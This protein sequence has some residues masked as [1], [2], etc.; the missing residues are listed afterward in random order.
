MTHLLFILIYWF[1]PS[2]DSV[3][4]RYEFNDES[5]LFLKGNTNVTAFKCDCSDNYRSGKVSYASD[6]STGKLTFFN[7]SIKIPSKSLDCRNRF[8]NR[9]LCESLKA[10]K[11]PEIE[12]K[13]LEAVPTH[14][15]GALDKNGL[16]K[17]K[18]KA[19]IK[20]AG[21]AKPQTF[22]VI[23]QKRGENQFRI[24][25]TEDISMNEYDIVPKSPLKFIKIED[26]ISIHFELNVSLES[27]H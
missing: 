2:L 1:H 3:T 20:I 19:L 4:L 13:L 14:G 9:D 5:R 12:V 23:L 8:I 15:S 21:A 17:Y 22:E 27:Y 18:A 11:Y 10:D 6:P 24:F 26:A 25:A 7:T 16:Y